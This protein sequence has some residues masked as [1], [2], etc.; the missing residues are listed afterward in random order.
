MLVYTLRTGDVLSLEALWTSLDLE[1][2]LRTLFERPVPVHLDRRK[3]HEHII[4]VG[5][6]DKSVALGGVKPFHNTFFS[7]YLSPVIDAR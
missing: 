2:H 6:L 4:A 7:H 1:L 3:V 5:T